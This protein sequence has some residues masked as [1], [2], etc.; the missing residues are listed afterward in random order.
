[1]I[2]ELHLGVVELFF[3]LPLHTTQ[4]L[5]DCFT[6][7]GVPSD[8]SLQASGELEICLIQKEPVFED[9]VI[10]LPKA[11]WMVLKKATAKRTEQS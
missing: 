4:L 8:P 11:E 3:S 9:L 7:A 5:N 10:L 6:S 1:M 2:E